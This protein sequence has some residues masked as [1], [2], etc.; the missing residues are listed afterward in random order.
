MV[1]LSCA[2]IPMAIVLTILKVIDMLFGEKIAFGCK[3]NIFIYISR[4]EQ[5]HGNQNWLTRRWQYKWERWAKEWLGK[6]GSSEDSL[7]VNIKD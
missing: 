4:N 2:L 6:G 5:N 1:W 7:K 3:R